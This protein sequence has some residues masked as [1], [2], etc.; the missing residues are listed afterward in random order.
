LKVKAYKEKMS[1]ILT[2]KHSKELSEE[3]LLLTAEVLRTNPDIHTLWNYRKEIIGFFKTS[4]SEE[5][6]CSQ[7]STELYL[8]EVCLKANPKSYYTWFHRLWS[9]DNLP[10]PDLKRELALCSKYLQLDSRNF[11]CWDYRRSIVSRLQVPPSEELSFTTEKIEQDF[12]NYSSWHYRSKLLPQISPDP[13]GV[14]PIDEASHLKEL[15]LTENAAFTDP[16]DQSAWFYQ[17]WLLGRCEPP[18]KLTIA[19]LTKQ[20]LLLAFNRPVSPHLID[21]HIGSNG[22]PSF[23]EI[24]KGRQLN[25]SPNIL[26]FDFCGALKEPLLKVTHLGASETLPLLPNK[27]TFYFYRKP[28]FLPEFSPLLLDV[29]KAQLDS[30]NQLLELEPESK[31]T[32]LTSVNLMVAIDRGKYNDEIIG[33]LRLLCKVD[34]LRVAYYNDLRS[35]YTIEHKF[36]ESNFNH[37]DLSNCNLTALYHSEYFLLAESVDLRGNKLGKSLRSLQ[38]LQS[39]KKLSL[40]DN[41]LRSLEGFPKDLPLVESL[42]LKDNLLGDV[43][44]IVPHVKGLPLDSLDLS[45]NPVDFLSIKEALP[46]LRQLN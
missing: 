44:A 2:M 1:Q 21:I 13:L 41:G 43:Q 22:S 24:N 25:K 30:C 8:T 27:D 17:R 35:K 28:K 40:E 42:S 39:C 14:R 15:D 38:S 4:K 11:H 34:P 45:G 9:L 12:S 46:S 23:E 37:F 20:S 6:L 29:L 26:A 16:N 5:E 32:L 7:L 19:L 31:W 33:R 36:E 3:A 10:Q 18:V